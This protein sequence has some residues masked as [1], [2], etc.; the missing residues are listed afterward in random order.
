MAE[1]PYDPEYGS[2]EMTYYAI[3]SSPNGAIQIRA[4]APETI[5]DI[6]VQR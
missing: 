4:C 3:Y 1:I 2:P 6:S 5:D